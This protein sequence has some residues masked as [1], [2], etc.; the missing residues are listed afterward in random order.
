MQENKIN[1][2]TANDISPRKKKRKKY[3]NH[4]YDEF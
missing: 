3:L 1:E 4:F 2:K